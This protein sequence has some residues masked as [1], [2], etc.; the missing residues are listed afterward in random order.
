MTN[1]HGVHAL[2]V[3]DTSTDAEVL[4]SLL[5]RH[6]VTYDLINDS[7]LVADSL[8]N[9]TA[10]TVV[11]LDLDLPG[12][13]GYE[14]LTMLRTMPELQNTP[15]VAYTSHSSEMSTAREAGFDGFLGKPLKQGLFATQLERI[16]NNEGVWET[17]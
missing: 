8:P 4:R 13:N 1:F 15:V 11:F 12:P 14:V 10:P 5:D 16:L 2:I 9:M 6:G 3:E 7:R 17:R